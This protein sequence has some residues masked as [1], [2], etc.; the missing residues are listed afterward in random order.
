MPSQLDS[1]LIGLAGSHVTRGG[2]RKGEHSEFVSSIKLYLS[3][4]CLHRKYGLLLS[5]VVIWVGA[6]LESLAV[7]PIMFIV[8]RFVVGLNSGGCGTCSGVWYMLKWFCLVMLYLFF[9][10]STV[11][12]FPLLLSHPAS[13]TPFL[14]PFSSPSP[15]GLVTV[16]VPLY[17]SEV[18]P[19]GLRGTMG[20]MHQMAITSTIL[21]SNVF[22]LHQVYAAGGYPCSQA[23]PRFL[24]LAVRKL[25]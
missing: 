17:I 8:G 25:W 10:V 6:G 3:T 12:N 2:R 23:L 7:H 16:L 18:S 19:V 21:L 20:V 5:N 24:L 22:G 4:H 9:L 13:L 15:L 14:T 1:W 11:N